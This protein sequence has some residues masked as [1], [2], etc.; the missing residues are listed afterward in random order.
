MQR[1]RQLVLARQQRTKENAK[2]RRLNKGIQAPDLAGKIFIPV[3]T[4]YEF[5]QRNKTNQRK[6]IQQRNNPKYRLSKSGEKSQNRTKQET[7][8]GERCI[9]L[10]ATN[11]DSAAHIADICRVVSSHF[12]RSTERHPKKH[13][14]VF[15]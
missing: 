4:G 13:W 5:Y 9:R 6:N 1:F 2:R 12:A 3:A 14:Y 8:K 15:L 10:G 7:R 11:G